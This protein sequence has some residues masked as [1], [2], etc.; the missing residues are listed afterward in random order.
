[1]DWEDKIR[2]FGNVFNRYE[3]FCEIL[4]QQQVR[5][6]IFRKDASIWEGIIDTSEYAE[7]CMDW[8]DSLTRLESVIS[9]VETLSQDVDTVVLIGTGGASLAANACYSL[10]R[11]SGGRSLEVLDSTSPHF[12][13]QYFNNA[14]ASNRYYIVASKSGSTIETLDVATSL[15]DDVRIPDKFCVIT[16]P[17]PSS[18]RSWAEQHAIKLYSSDPFVPGRYSSLSTLGTIPLKILGCDLQEMHKMHEVYTNAV[19]LGNSDSSLNVEKTAALIAALSSDPR[20]RIVISGVATQLPVV[21]WVEQLVAESLGK[22][23][24]GILPV[25]QF[26]KSNQLEKHQV[27]VRVRL[28]GSEEVV[29]YDGTLVDLSQITEFFLFWQSVIS[30]CGYLLRIDPFDQPNVEQSKQRVFESLRENKAVL[31]SNQVPDCIADGFKESSIS[32]RSI[33]T[34]IKEESEEHHYVGLLAFV[35]PDL[36]TAC[37]FNHLAKKLG[38]WIGL[39]TVFNFGPQYLHSTGQFHK[40]G[41]AVGHYLVISVEDVNDIQVTDRP[42]TFRKIFDTQRLADMEVLQELGR[43]IYNIKFKRSVHENIVALLEHL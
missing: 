35:E 8:T 21:Q 39:T 29:I 27:S 38:E 3:H 22:F 37:M 32:L 17:T 19:M 34:Q 11:I 23:G 43:P 7:R 1:M 16:D 24:F 4:T 18:L 36:L 26:D 2:D 13:Q 9:N 10:L 28:L 15:F 14:A 5:S 12:L 6:R 42:Y 33:L 20:S 30:M 25:V 41:P 40:G 31:E